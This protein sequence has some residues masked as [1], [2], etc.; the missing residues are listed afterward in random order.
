LKGRH[1]SSDAEVIGATETGWTD[2]LLNFYEWLAKVRVWSLYL[3]SFL[4]GLRT[5]QHP[6]TEIVFLYLNLTCHHTPQMWLRPSHDLQYPTKL[7]TLYL[8]HKCHHGFKKWCV[9]RK[10]KVHLFTHS[11]TFICHQWNSLL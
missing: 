9:A 4:V 11:K 8:S 2:S 10:K 1:F 6:G 5:Y 3:V 7:P